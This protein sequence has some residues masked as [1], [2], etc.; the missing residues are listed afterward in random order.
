ML[1]RCQGDSKRHRPQPILRALK[2]V[3]EAKT[4]SLKLS[5]NNV[6]VRGQLK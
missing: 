1:A 5:I 4:L 6:I 2:L 3:H